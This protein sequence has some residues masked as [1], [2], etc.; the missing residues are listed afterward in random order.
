MRTGE[1]AV[2]FKEGT[3]EDTTMDSFAEYYADFLDQQYDC[4]DRIVLNAYFDLGQSPGGFRTWWKR[5]HGTADNLDNAH[6]MRMAG[7]FSRRVRGWAKKHGIPIVACQADD[8]KHEMA[9]ELLPSQPRPGIFA[10]LVSRAPYPVW[11]VQHWGQGG[12]HL[13]RKKPQPYVNHYSFQIWDAEWGHLTIKICGHPP[14][15][16]QIMLNGHEYVAQQAQ[17]RKI[18]FAK[19]GN[20][21]TEWTNAAGLNRV[22]ETLR[23][24]TAIGRLASVCERWIYRC[25]CFALDVTEQ[26]T[27]DFR[28][29]YSVYQV[30]YSRNYLFQRGHDLDQVFAGV[31]DRTR[32]ALDLKTVKT[33]FGCKQRPRRHGK[34]PRWE[35]V[36]EKP[37]YDLTVF[38]IHCGP[39]TLKMYSKGERVLRCEVILHNARRLAYGRKLDKFPQ[40]VEH[41]EGILERFVEVVRCVDA[42][43]LGPDVLERLAQPTQVG[44]ARVAGVDWNKPRL[45]A[46]MA[47]V[48]AVS[49][50]PGDGFTSGQI[51]TQVRE[52]LGWPEEDYAAR[53][54]SYDLKKLRGQ[55]LIEKVGTSAKYRAPAEGLRTLAG[56]SVLRDQVLQPV[57]AGAAKPKP[58]R[59]PRPAGPLEAHYQAIRKEMRGLFQALRI[60]A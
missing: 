54:A 42:S 23:S 53:Q 20:C 4:V 46:L 31:I 26:Q 11:D 10:V 39:W 16:A 35:V 5:L 49:A 8:R 30:E 22:A 15:T 56:L 59:P 1:S 29:R 33:L 60:P 21:F 14:F 55:G 58:G 6:L 28:Y 2:F 45:R 51:A 38:K 43:C 37:S 24:P 12:I 3:T 19:E 47:A 7:R 34:T 48:V 57:L 41:L 17:R 44:K 32:A 25:L 52:R 9:E 50:L 18:V 40:I 27:T 13:E 36:V